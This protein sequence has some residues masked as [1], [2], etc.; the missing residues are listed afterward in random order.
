MLNETGLNLAATN[1]VSC[2]N[3][4]HVMA[5]FVFN[6]YWTHVMLLRVSIAVNNT[7]LS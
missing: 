2:N 7:A 1:A 6:C 3:C 4:F 5:V